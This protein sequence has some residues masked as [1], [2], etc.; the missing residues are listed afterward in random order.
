MRAAVWV[1]SSLAVCWIV[2]HGETSCAATSIFSG[3]GTPAMDGV[4]TPAEWQ[5]AGV[6]NLSVNTPSVGTTPAILYVM[7]DASKIYLAL[8][9]LRNPPDPR[10]SLAFYFDKD[11]DNVVSI[12]DDVILLNVDP[13]PSTVLFDEVV[14]PCCGGEG[15]NGQLDTSYGGTNDGAGAFGNDGTY[16]VFELWHPLRS[17]DSAH[18]I[19]LSPGQSI[20]L[21][22]YLRLIGTNNIGADT[23]TQFMTAV[24]AAGPA[25]TSTP[26]PTLAGWGPA[27]L[28]ALI[29]LAYWSVAR[30]RAA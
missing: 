19:Q 8:R 17:S 14:E 3:W 20:G 25:A 4:Y 28:A 6:V 5:G 13:P 1:L 18:D 23:S 26:I 24:L 10:N 9:I 29:G 16:S 12:G 7:N 22:L 27:A 21:S 15:I 11:G 30:R 2:T